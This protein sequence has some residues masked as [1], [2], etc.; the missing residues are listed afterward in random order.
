MPAP[1]PGPLRIDFDLA[2]Y[3]PADDGARACSGTPG[4]AEIVVCGARRRGGAYPMAQWARIFATRP[5]VAET[6]IAGNLRGDVHAE[7]VP[8]DRGA[9]SNRV[10]IRLT[11]PF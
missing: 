1:A 4:P 8:L 10:M 11:V 6:G 5:L 7:A 2:R 3:R 9:V